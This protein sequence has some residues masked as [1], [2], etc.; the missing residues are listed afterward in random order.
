MV[1]ITVSPVTN[2]LPRDEL[3]K[4]LPNP[5]AVRAFEGMQ[6]DVT[7]TIPDAMGHIV[8]LTNELAAAPYV[9]WAETPTLENERTLVVTSTLTV[10]NTGSQI[11]L[12]LRETGFAAGFY[13]SATQTLG[14]QVDV[15]GRVTGAQTYNLLSDNVAE[16]TQHLYYTDARA[17]GAIS[18]SAGIGYNNTTGAISLTDTAVTPGTYGSATAVPVLTIDQQGRTTGATTAALPLLASGTYTPTLTPIANITGSTAYSCQYMR[19]GNVVSVSGRIDV[20]ATASGSQT[21]LGISLPIPSAFTAATQC[22]GTACAAS[23]SGQVAG[24]Q[25]DYPISR[26]VL[27]MIPSSTVMQPML[28]TFQYRVL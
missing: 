14:L 24:I 3:A 22:G 13:G 9:T 18:G 27:S 19:V 21:H 26:A 12:G 1:A 11:V 20:Q 15:F 10:N 2:V 5:R 8:D 23:A 25:A 7:Q 17:R 4:F 6:T 28:M 16:G